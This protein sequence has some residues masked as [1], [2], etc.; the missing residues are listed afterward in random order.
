MIIST[1]QKNPQPTCTSSKLTQEAAE[2]EA[3]S[4][5]S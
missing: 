4:V 5:Q 2:Q 1:Y 3:K